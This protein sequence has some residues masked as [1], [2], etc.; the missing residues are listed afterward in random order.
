MM[1]MVP[2]NVSVTNE[3]KAIMIDVLMCLCQRRSKAMTT[4]SHIT[5]QNGDK[6]ITKEANDRILQKKL[7]LFF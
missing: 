5:C 2:L 4:S 7:D 1:T 6:R 3:S